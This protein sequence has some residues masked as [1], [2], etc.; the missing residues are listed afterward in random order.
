[1]DGS[2]PVQP[3]EAAAFYRD[4]VFILPRG[5]E[6]DM[7]VWAF[8]IHLQRGREGERETCLLCGSEG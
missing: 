5:L 4:D 8:E 2:R 6:K 3:G 1:M 7:S